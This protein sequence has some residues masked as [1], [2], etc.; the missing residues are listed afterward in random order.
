MT[1]FELGKIEPGRQKSNH[2]M[3]VVM[4]WRARAAAGKGSIRQGSAWFV[5]PIEEKP[6]EESLAHLVHHAS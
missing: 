4:L 1:A 3:A 6:Q 5:L 2:R